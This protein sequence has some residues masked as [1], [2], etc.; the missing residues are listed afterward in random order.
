[1][2]EVPTLNLSSSGQA[3]PQVGFGLWK[4]PPTET[5]DIVYQVHFAAPDQ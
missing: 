3:I 4:V 2:S 5:A 1:M